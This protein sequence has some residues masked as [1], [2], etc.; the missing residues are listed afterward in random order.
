MGTVGV[1]L[2]WL[3]S[4]LGILVSLRILQNQLLRAVYTDKLRS[5]GINVKF[6]GLITGCW[7]SGRSH[8]ELPQQLGGTE[9][10]TD[11][12]S[13]PSSF[14]ISPAHPNIQN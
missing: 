4:G 7:G 11:E 2:G 8:H 6:W 1:V 9:S 10:G 13:T 12:H 3:S 14:S 5:S